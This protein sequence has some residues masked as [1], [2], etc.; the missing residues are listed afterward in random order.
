MPADSIPANDAPLRFDGRSN[1]RGPVLDGQ[2]QRDFLE[3]TQL[4]GWELAYSYSVFWWSVYH[5]CYRPRPG[6]G[7]GL[8][9]QWV[10]QSRQAISNCDQKSSTSR[11][12]SYWRREW[13]V[14]PD[15]TG[16]TRSQRFGCSWPEPL[17]SFHPNIGW[18]DCSDPHLYLPIW[19]NR[20]SRQQGKPVSPNLYSLNSMGLSPLEVKGEWGCRIWPFDA[21]LWI[22][23][24]WIPSR[25]VYRCSLA[26]LML[27]PESTRL[28]LKFFS[29]S[30][31]YSRAW[32]NHGWN[33]G[34]EGFSLNEISRLQSGKLIHTFRFMAQCW[35]TEVP[36]T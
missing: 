6:L 30:A 31:P 36:H 4:S 22:L 7:N 12:Y 20:V 29:N 3:D 5:L 27:K 18:P 17:A 10:W 25:K 16:R 19:R 32:R 1:D 24:L 26:F 23:P 2:Q 21:L 13:S 8:C 9:C 33:A 11:W 15:R 34:W 35:R 14:S 28:F